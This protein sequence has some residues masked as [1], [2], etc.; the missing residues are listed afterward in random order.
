MSPDPGE[1]AQ[2]AIPLA[3]A[4][5]WRTSCGGPGWSQARSSGVVPETGQAQSGRGQGLDRGAGLGVRKS[6]H[7]KHIFLTEW[8]WASREKEGSSVTVRFWLERLAGCC[9]LQ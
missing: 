4:P 5:A 1:G 6:M 7:S 8:V 2:A 3:L 9:V